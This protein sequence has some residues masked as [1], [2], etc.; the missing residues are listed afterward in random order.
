MGVEIDVGSK[1]LQPSLSRGG[2]KQ[3]L[4]SMRLWR[5]CAAPRTD[6][7]KRRRLRLYP[8]ANEGEEPY[9][10]VYAVGL[11]GPAR[12][13]PRP[14]SRDARGVGNSVTR[15]AVV[16]VKAIRSSGCDINVA[17]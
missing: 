3:P 10:V 1:L 8:R 16:G 12:P 11:K 2:G 14:P 6:K 5:H 9:D 7:Q 15:Q 4:L 13:L 17:R